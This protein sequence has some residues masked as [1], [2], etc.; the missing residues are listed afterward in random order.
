[1][2]DTV[3]SLL[4]SADVYAW[5]VSDV[6][7]DAWEFY[8]IRH[9]LDQNRVRHVEHL[10][11]KV[12]RLSE[13]GETMGSAS[14]EVPPT[15][16]REEAKALI[17]SLSYRASLIKNKPYTLHQPKPAVGASSR[18]QVDPEEISRT[19]LSTMRDLPETPTE[20]VNS[21]E[22]FVASKKRCFL[23]SEGVDVAEAYPDSMIE[24]I[25][26]ARMPEHEIELYRNFKS[27]T[28]DATSLRRDVLRA[29]KTGRDRLSAVP[30]P[31]LGK[32]DVIF[33]AADACELYS[34]FAA[35]LDAAMIYRRMSTWELGKSICPVFHGDAPSLSAVRELPNS[36][37]NRLFDAEGAP[38]RDLPLLENGIARNYHGS[39][40]FSAY[41]GL[42]DS[43]IPSN[44]VVEGGSRGESELRQGPYLEVVEFSDFQVDA[45]A[46]DLFGE[47]RLAYWHDGEKTV[48]VSGGSISG[49][50]LDLAGNMELSS[51]TVQYNNWRIPS[52]TLL[53]GVTVTGIA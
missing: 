37:A 20:D 11:V 52:V 49:S 39:R 18:I 6:L 38:I 31:A 2:L 30:T 19:F 33:S 24:V 12:Y 15:A 13:D 8:M 50:M 14:C 32:A 35:R 44:Y 28:C 9:A 4:R 3:V 27:G 45:V 46:G 36:S 42:E 41:L 51:E 10:T 43:F 16:S 29:M 47:I 53:R 25:V 17:E 5:E 21:Y 40:M 7:T 34:Y 23:N 1:M 48:A 26:N 22:I